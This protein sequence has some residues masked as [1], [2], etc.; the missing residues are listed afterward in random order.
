MGASDIRKTLLATYVPAT[1]EGAFVHTYDRRIDIED[2]AV[3][4][5]E[6][7]ASRAKAPIAERAKARMFAEM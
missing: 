5:A 6:P 3:G 7:M 2:A 1:L 4:M